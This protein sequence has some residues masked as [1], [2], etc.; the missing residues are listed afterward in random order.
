MTIDE[1]DKAFGEARVRFW[2]CLNR[3]HRVV[4]W[5][6]DVATCRDCGL[7]SEMT[8]QLIVLTRQV[9]LEQIE[10]RF[11]SG[12]ATLDELWNAVRTAL[13]PPADPAN[14]PEWREAAAKIRGE[15]R[16]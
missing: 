16:A 9:A 4:D 7:T 5:S 6:G 3:D 10:A 1:L 14:N 2:R 15:H 8:K 11:R 12:V 13:E